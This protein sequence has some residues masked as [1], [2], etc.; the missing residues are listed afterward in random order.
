MWAIYSSIVTEQSGKQLALSGI[1]C[2]L[3]SAIKSDLEYQSEGNAI[4]PPKSAFSSLD[5][6]KLKKLENPA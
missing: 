6:G 2:T 1:W 5:L 4:P 3:D